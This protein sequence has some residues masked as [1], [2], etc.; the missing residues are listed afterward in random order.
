[1]SDV[2]LRTDKAKDRRD[3]AS[4]AA[5]AQKLFGEWAAEEEAGYRGEVSWEEFKREINVGR[6]PHSSPFRESSS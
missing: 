3:T 4:I 1:V 2:A 5:E 6:P